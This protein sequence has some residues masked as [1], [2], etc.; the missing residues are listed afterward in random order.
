M[1]DQLFEYLNKKKEIDRDTFDSITPLFRP[2]RVKRK[3]L[4]LRAG[5][6]CRYNYFINRGCLRLYTINDQARES[7]RYFAF[8]GKFGTAFS[9][10]IEG[11]PSFEFLEAIEHS[12][13]L[14]IQRR[15]FYEL[16]ETVPAVNA[17]YRNMLEMAYVTSQRRI[18]DLL[19]ES[20]L[21]RLK[22]LLDCQPMILTRLSSKVVASYLG[23]TPYTLSRLKAE[24]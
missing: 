16:V 10:L 2:R 6:T 11:S 4:L 5:E 1:Y 20:A 19:G 12:E 7:T 3:T 13:M 14:A 8:E 18:Y 23:V 21:E 9:S 17:V 15:D 22:W 24:L